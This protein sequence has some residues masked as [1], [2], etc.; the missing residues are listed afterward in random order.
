MRL[1]E[2]LGLRAVDE[3][4]NALGEVHDVRLQE[5]T[6]GDGHRRFVVDGILLRAGAVG[7]RLGYAYGQVAGPRLLAW[8]M[9][10]LARR[11]LYVPWT[12]VTSFEGKR[13][14]VG[15][16]VQAMVH[17]DEHRRPGR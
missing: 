12:A 11:A 7:A 5:V 1:S 6:D 16:S 4:D 9:R 2:M 8:A 13:L 3:D 15:T 17:P 14:I 10:R